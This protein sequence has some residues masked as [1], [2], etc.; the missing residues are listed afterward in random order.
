MRFSTSKDNNVS[1]KQYVERMKENQK[2]IYFIA[3]DNLEQLKLSPFVEKL[4]K[5]DLEV[6]Y[7]HDTIDEYMMQQLKEYENKK[8]VDCSKENF[9]LEETQEEKEKFEEKK[10]QYSEFCEFIKKTLGD[11]IEKAEI[12]KRLD[13]TPCILSTTEYSWSANMQKIMQSQALSGN[14]MAMYMRSKKIMEINPE[15]ELIQ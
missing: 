3:G 13:K 2:D 7:M 1:L 5:R 12:S 8:F 9:A 14:E 6:I 10:K 11:K 15:T 4:K